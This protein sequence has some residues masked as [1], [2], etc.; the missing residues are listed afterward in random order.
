MNITLNIVRLRRLKI[1]QLLKTVRKYDTLQTDRCI[2]KGGE[3]FVFA[4]LTIFLSRAGP[5]VCSV[6]LAQSASSAALLH[7]NYIYRVIP[8]IKKLW[9][10]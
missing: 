9:A 10:T 8:S 4:L 3:N 6:F 7:R 5:S 1:S 2:T